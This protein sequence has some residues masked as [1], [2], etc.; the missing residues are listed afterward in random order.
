M[1]L[2]SIQTFIQVAE[3]KNFTKVAREMNYVQSTVT[4]QIQQL[5]R[6]LGFPLFDRIGKSVSLTVLGEEFLRYAYEMVALYKK[7]TGLGVSAGDI[8]GTLRVGVLESLLFGTV[9]DM[10][11]NYKSNH[12][13]VE[14]HL[15]MGQA[16]ELLQQLRENRLDLVYLSS[17]PNF[18]ADLRCC[19][20]RRETLR[21]ISCPKHPAAQ[22][23]NLSI[24]QLLR[25]EFVVTEQTGIC[26]GRLRKLAD[27]HHIPLKA[28]IEVDSTVA[29]CNLVQRGVGIAFLPEY[30]VSE[31][32]M[33]GTLV[34]LDV[35]PEPQVYYS[36]ILCHRN[37]WISPIMQNFIDAVQAFRPAEP[38]KHECQTTIPESFLY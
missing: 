17:D 2:K 22:A 24:E 8:H 28:A 26:Y 4:M 15:K 16:A 1:D 32:L 12:P 27:L 19:Y 10:L 31:Q 38:D 21:F 37:R 34:K 35:T 7:A 13:N 25:Y 29:I 9:L 18:D 36:Q 30:S 14:L 6:E 20:K 5:E 23:G 33:Q 11:P 3:Q